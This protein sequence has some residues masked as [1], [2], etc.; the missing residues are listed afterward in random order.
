MFAYLW[1]VIPA[2]FYFLIFL[3]PCFS[4]FSIVNLSLVYPQPP[5]KEALYK[6]TYIKY[7]F[8]LFRCGISQVCPNGDALTKFS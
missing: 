2:S 3:F 1:H 6:Y 7:S 4:I 8:Q 5:G